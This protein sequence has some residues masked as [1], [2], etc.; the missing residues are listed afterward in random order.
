MA[1]KSLTLK[2][3]KMSLKEKQK[4][5]K[6]KKQEEKIKKEKPG[7]NIWFWFVKM[8]GRL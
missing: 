4:E 6:L 3:P 2:E 1:K 5:K 7:L 8:I